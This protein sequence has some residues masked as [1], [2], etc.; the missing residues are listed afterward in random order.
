M[1]SIIVVGGDYPKD[2][3]VVEDEDDV[4]PRRTDVSVD[5]PDKGSNI[6]TESVNY[7]ETT[8]NK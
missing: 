7:E 4:S 2:K 6:E 1:E 5:V 8:I 3:Y